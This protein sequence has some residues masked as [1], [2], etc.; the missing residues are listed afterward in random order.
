MK[1]GDGGATFRPARAG[2]AAAIARLVGDAYRHYVPRIGAEPG[3][4]RD[5][6]AEVVARGGVWVAELDDQLVGLLVLVTASDH[7]LVENVAVAPERQGHGLGRQLLDFAEERAREA[8]A[9]E[10]RL[11]THERMTE[12]LAIYAER[13]YRETHRDTMRGLHRVHLAKPLG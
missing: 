7:V 8:G 12:N 10:I 1:I 5:D 4:M 3:P 13:G 9:G 11:Y 2:D 6:Y